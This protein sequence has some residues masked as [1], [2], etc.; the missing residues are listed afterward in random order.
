MTETGPVTAVAGPFFHAAAV[1]T[2]AEQSACRSASAGPGRVAGAVTD[3]AAQFPIPRVP[4]RW[5]RLLSALIALALV[6]ALVWV[7]HARLGWGNVLARWQGI[8]PSLI[9]TAFGLFVL[10]ALGRALRVHAFARQYTQGRLVTVLRLTL[11][12]HTINTF[13]P[14]RTGEVAYP[15]LMH[16]YFGQGWQGSL[17]DLLWLRLFDL[18]C[19][20]WAALVC[21]G[22]ASLHWS[23]ALATAIGW[24]AMVPIGFAVLRR[25]GGVFSTRGRVG[26]LIG[27]LLATAPQRWVATYLYTA[28]VWLSRFVALAVLLGAFFPISVATAAVAISVG[29]LSFAL[30]VNGFASAGT[31]EAAIVGAAAIWLDDLDGLLAA[32]VNVHL[33]MLGVTAL[34]GAVGLLLPVQ[35]R[36]QEQLRRGNSADCDGSGS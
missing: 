33:F 6:I 15:A 10:S 16:R 19:L 4:P 11:L 7:V 27:R 29:E 17:A 31:Y 35:R 21:A 2:S 8:A 24:M 12:H 28:M 3:S 36:A 9:A 22:F 32:A 34:L 25:L 1:D 23:V 14:A 5:R 13:M 20:L 18:H 30:P 26:A